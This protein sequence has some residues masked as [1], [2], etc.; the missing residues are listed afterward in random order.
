MVFRCPNIQSHYNETVICLNFGIPENN[1]FSIWD[2]WKFFYFEVSQYLS[3][4]GYC[5]FFAYFPV[6]PIHIMAEQ[7]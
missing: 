1:D 3:T 2:K 5:S 4:L 7:M 6:T